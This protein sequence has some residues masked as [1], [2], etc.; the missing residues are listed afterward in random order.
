MPELTIDNQKVEVKQGNTILDAARKLGIDIPTLCFNEACQPSSSC[1]VCVVK[2]YGRL[3]PSCATVVEEGM[4][5]ESET[6]EIY[7]ARRTALELLLS[8]HVGDCIAP[9]HSICPA[10]MNIPLMIRQIVDGRLRDAII[11][12]KRDIP[13]PAVLGRICPAPCENG[14]RRSSYDDPVSICLL[15]RYVADM[16]LSSGSPYL[17][18]C[19]SANGKK[20]AIIGA[21]PAGLS[22]AYYLLQE[23]FACILFDDHEKPGGSL[24]YAVPEDKLPRNIL[25]AEIGIVEKLGAEFRMRTVI[26]GDI[27]IGDLQRDYDAILIATGNDTRLLSN[28]QIDRNTL[29]TNIGGVFVG[30]NATGRKSNMTVRSVAD[31]KIASVSVA[32]YISNLPVV[33]IHKQ[34]TVRMGKLA[35]EE[36]QEFMAGVSKAPRRVSSSGNAGFSEQEAHIESLRCLRC[37][38]RKSDNCKLRNYAEAY[39]ANPNKYK[40]ERKLFKRY[41]QHP[42]IIY[43]PGKCIA[44]GLCIQIASKAREAMGLAF[45]GRGF[46][47]RVGVPFN[48][49]IAEGLQKVAA[50]CADACPTG[51]L[52]LK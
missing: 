44:C 43:E 1:M 40:R 10:G 18:F 29:Q 42:D 25:D 27:S 9:C 31:G 17:P 6:D 41:I 35:G 24:Q 15:K 30:G 36:I 52:A 19:K 5:V 8:D 21:G 49:S 11:T 2:V 45:I 47:V 28:I 3:V 20:V 50:Q 7:E 38:C 23:G 34:F 48:R 14:C 16:D 39:G 4:E 12:V 26:G 33:G 32:Q 37:D 51:A 46:N 13:L 22:A